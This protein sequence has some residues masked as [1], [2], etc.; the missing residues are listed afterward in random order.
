[1]APTPEMPQDVAAPL[2]RVV[3][4][5]LKTGAPLPTDYADD[6]RASRGFARSPY[7]DGLVDAPQIP[8]EPMSPEAGQV[9]DPAAAPPPA[10]AGSLMDD[11]RAGWLQ[12]QMIPPGLNTTLGINEVVGGMNTTNPREAEMAA[13][14]VAVEQG[15]SDLE[16]QIAATTDTAALNELGRARSE[17]VA[18]RDSLT[19]VLNAGPD[20]IAQGMER[21][22]RSAPEIRRLGDE[23]AAIPID[24]AAEEMVAAE[25]FGEGWEA[26][27][28]NPDAVMRTMT[29]RSLPS[30]APSI[31]GAI[32]G[33]ALGGP[34][35]GGAAAGVAGG[36]TEMGMSVAQDM[37]AVLRA[38]GVDPSDRDA[39]L[40]AIEANPDTFSNILTD[41][42]IRAGV[43][44][45][46]DAV[47]GGLSGALAKWATGASRT[48]RVGAVAAGG[49]VDTVGEGVGEGGAQLATDGT[50]QPGE[51][52]AE[53]A[54]GAGQ[55]SV[56]TTGQMIAEAL[57][58]APQQ[59]VAPEGEETPT[60]A[61]PAPEQR[62]ARPQTQTPPVIEMPPEPTRPALPKPQE[63]IADAAPET[64]PS[65]EM[66]DQEE[67][68]DP[69][70][71]V[72]RGK[73]RL[74]QE[75]IE[76]PKNQMQKRPFTRRV[77]GERGVK[78]GSPAAQELAAAGVTPRTAPPGL[79]NN[80]GHSDLDNIPA[81]EMREDYPGLKEDGNGYV[82]RQWMLDQIVREAAGE[83]VYTAEQQRLA[84]EQRQYNEALDTAISATPSEWDEWRGAADQAAQDEP[85]TF[86]NAPA[87]I[88]P[89]DKDIST[90]I[91][92]FQQ[93]TSSVDA[94]AEEIGLTLEPG[95]R[96]RAI[97]H[98]ERNG[99]DVAMALAAE[100]E[101]SMLA[102]IGGQTDVEAGQG[103]PGSDRPGGASPVGPEPVARA[104]EGGGAIEGEPSADP[105]APAEEPRT[106]ARIGTDDDGQTDLT[107]EGRQAVIP[108]AEQ[109]TDKQRAE[110]QQQAPKRGGNAAPPA[111]G[112]FDDDARNQT[113]M[114][115]DDEGAVQD[116]AVAGRRPKGSLTPGFLKFSFNNRPSVYQ[117]AL[118]DAGIDPA[119]ARLMDVDKQI[120]TIADMIREKF[121]VEIV[122]PRE[123][124]V[125][126]NRFGRKGVTSKQG[127][128]SREALDQLLDAYQQMQAMAAVV[129]VPEKA[130]GLPING[131][132]I[133]LSLVATKR[134]R[135]A[136]GMF[137]WGN[138]ER[139]IYLP[140][141]SNSF[142]HEWG[143]ALDHYLNNMVDKPTFKGMLTRNMEEKGLIPPLSPRRQVTDAFAHLMWSMFG[144]S[145]QIGA[146]RLR[147]QVQAAQLGKDGKSTP[148][149]QRA[150]K[151]LTDM[152]EGRRP[153]QEL[154]SDYFKSSKEF[155]DAYG[156][157]GYFTDAAE[158][159][160]RAFEAFVGRA[161]EA[162][163][164]GK[165][166]AFLSKSGWA[167]DDSSDDRL[168]LTFPKGA[169]AEQFAIAMTK[170]GQ[171]MRATNLF[172]PGAAAKMPEAGAMFSN[173][174]LLMRQPT[175]G[176]A[177]QEREAIRK[178]LNRLKSTV[179]R[180]A[181]SAAMRNAGKF[182][183]DVWQQRVN[184]Q[185][186]MMVAVADRQTN[187][188]A[189]AA[190]MNI[191]R[192]IAKVRPGKGEFHGSIY[193]EEVE[194]SANRR[195]KMVE[196]AIRKAFKGRSISDGDKRIVRAL[197]TGQSPKDATAAH[198]SLAGDIRSILNEVW[199]DLRDAGIE[200]SFEKDYLPHI[201]EKELID[202]DQDGFRAKAREVYELVFNREVMDNDDPETQMADVNSIIR[203][204]RKAVMATVTGDVETDSRL[205]GAD[206][207]LI[208]SF[209][210]AMK[211]LKDLRRRK[212]PDQDKIAEQ[213]DLVEDLRQEMLDM[214]RDRWSEYS[215]DKWF[216]ALGVGH[217]NEFG[218]IAPT[219]S[220]IKKRTLPKEAGQ[221]LSDFMSDDPM[222]IASGYIFAAARRAE[223]AKRYGAEGEKLKGMLTA[224]RE[225]GVSAED[226]DL[227]KTAMSAATGRMEPAASI[228]ARMATW[229]FTLGNMKVLGL[230]AFTSLTEGAV[231]AMRTGSVSDAARNMVSTVRM[232]SKKRRHDL[233]DL[234]SVV[235]LVA[236]YAMDNV[237]QNRMS[238]DALQ[239]SKAMKN[240]LSRFFVVSGLT[241]LTQF[242]RVTNL[243]LAHTFLA[244]ML[245]ANLGG[246][247][248]LNTVARDT[249]A[250][251]RG[252]FANDELNELGI[253]EGSRQDLLDW[254]EALDGMPTGDDMF[255]PDGNLHPA[256]ELYARAV[257]RFI[258][259]TIQNP[260][261]TDRPMMS[262]HPD[263]S[264][265]YGIMSFIDAFTRHILIRSAVRGIDE[266]DGLA[267]KG[268]KVGANT[269]L[270]LAPFAAV[271]AGHFAS[272]VLRETLLNSDKME[273]F[274]DDDERL[275]WLMERAFY[276]TGVVGR[277]DPVAQIVTGVKYE[278]D[279]TAISTG[280]YAAA[281]YQDVQTMMEAF[282]GRNSGNTNT[283]EHNAVTAAYR[284][285]GQPLAAAAISQMGPA[286][287]IS[288]WASRAALVGASSYGTGPAVADVFVGEKGDRYQGDPPWWEVGN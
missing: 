277:F 60:L 187:A 248:G 230:A 228:T 70:A 112:L 245:R 238:A 54:G 215:A 273:S 158:M 41:S 288:I 183:R 282:V 80:Q 285:I 69:A 272:T 59:P 63:E 268:L 270:T 72:E 223:Y 244:R 225:A 108:G 31:I 141:R 184:T 283:S 53:M 265:I 123:K 192:Q 188:K 258:N 169:D 136:L 127:I 119:D 37:D 240:M 15:I 221:I 267:V 62:P 66:V 208:K 97:A 74:A 18:Q 107:P 211:K 186:A 172:G 94:A 255:A 195:L 39:V 103:D 57:R 168:A 166:Q 5:A 219:N 13:E 56:T 55:G 142:A 8:V 78:P 116:A 111:G 193:Q 7:L 222:E 241:P 251:G 26:F 209:R 16:A 212:N 32:I 19:D 220:F 236:P 36:A 83:P 178:M 134:L 145:A 132:G 2:S 196:G 247:R 91:E 27:K 182:L 260:L 122:L 224:A 22:M 128:T 102:D 114:F 113:D 279:L 100:V 49:A 163:T 118:R 109:I 17:L 281:I 30:S 254:M 151:I 189:R 115:D 165:S 160:A 93:V 117:A 88:V 246:R 38:S 249:I 129:G 174:A 4:I 139:T 263:F 9:V 98:L 106:A 286:G 264:A 85:I 99:G 250:G 25:T 179:S 75:G 202:D 44:S 24:P 140:G 154:L 48:K 253:P 210:D 21:I 287:P 157:G 42:M 14:L 126:K 237:M 65:V 133:T 256:A 137:A 138:G 167:Y 159:F 257:N 229:A 280:P 73:E 271:Y 152:R 180:E 199:Y 266:D 204:L 161:V 201:Y 52:L 252:Q 34:I 214:L 156:A 218:A 173:K 121:G 96:A 104:P 82:D 51:V 233:W 11:L 124:R 105:S 191:T 125:R 29:A 12:A 206:E 149:A 243:P 40:A 43:I 144:D 232:L 278:R 110:R 1:M 147:L 90:D 58:K 71:A 262:N 45:A 259:E 61:L 143:H 227:L 101:R 50:F 67:P 194:R 205:S 200:V 84:D 217:M 239:Q 3:E 81:A 203:G 197:L 181:I 153:P 64:P 79:F 10:A 28:K 148:A 46:A 20:S 177:G 171:A 235:G 47:S 95:E 276:R 261:K 185:A 207:T 226:I 269:A 234:A 76:D 198:K 130:V 146:L 131:K 33:S 135:G 150:Q 86:Q 92:R 162:Q 68:V 216:T 170:L 213:T 175:L 23:I 242:Q 120:N 89:R 155:D 190:I 274:D 35:G 77:I 6:A 275:E 176:V 87:V 164:G 284:L 231:V